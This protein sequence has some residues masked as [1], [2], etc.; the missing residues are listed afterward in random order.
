[1]SFQITTAFVEQ[2]KAGFTQRVQQVGSKLRDSVRLESQG[3]KAAFYNFIGATTVRERTTRHGDSP[4][5]ETPH[6]RRMCTLRDYD[7][8]DYVDDQ[9]K[10]RT[11]NDPTNEYVNA[12]AMSMG[13][14]MDEII[15]DA[16]EATV[17]TGEHGADSVVFGSDGGS[18]IP[19]A[20]AG[21]DLDK[22][23]EARMIL[24][25]NEASEGDD[26]CLV[27]GAS[28]IGDLL[29]LE[30]ISSADYSAVKA[31]VKGELDT[32][33]GFKIIR[34]NESLL[35]YSGGNR[36]CYAWAKSKMLLALGSDIQA[37]ITERED[38]GFATYA[39]TSM[40]I[41]ALRMQGEG[42]V[43]IECVDAS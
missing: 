20:G 29:A 32:F 43:A 2:F 5:I 30:K 9:D 19:V 34:V 33:M 8:G 42:V 22:L 24:D 40:S 12:A 41:G 39:Y 13:R 3:G 25:G 6:T 37:K 10:L 26:L 18:T 28:Q 27:M 7:W 21:M 17:S 1:M 15:I 31:L 4:Y 11:M 38:K 16:F 14:K 36:T 23:I 35:P